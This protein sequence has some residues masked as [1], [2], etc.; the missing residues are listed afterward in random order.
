VVAEAALDAPGGATL[1]EG[2]QTSEQK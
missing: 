2:L 1:V